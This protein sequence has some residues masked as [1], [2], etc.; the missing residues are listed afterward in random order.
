LVALSRRLR[1]DWHFA[2]YLLPRDF[3]QLPRSPEILQPSAST[4]PRRR[5]PPGTIQAAFARY[6]RMQ[7]EVSSRS[8]RALLLL[9]FVLAV[10]SYW[11]L[12]ISEFAADYFSQKGDRVSLQRAI[13]LQPG[14]A[15]F[16]YRLGRYFWLVEQ[17]SESAEQSYQ[18]ALALNPYKA[19]YWLDLAAVYQFLGNATGQQDALEHAV[20][21]APTTPEVAWE[22]ANLFLVQGEKERALHEFRIVLEN[23]PHLQPAALQLCLRVQPD[24][25]ALLRDVV[26]PISSVYL[27]FLDLL[28]SKKDTIAAAKVWAQLAH[29]QQ[30]FEARYVFEYIRYLVG[31]REVDQAGRVWEQ[32]ARL[33][34]LSAYQ[35]S[36]NNLVING[37][38][39]LPVLNG[40]FD[41]LYE[42]SKDVSLALDPS[43]FHAGRRS[44]MLSFD[45]RGIEDAGIRH[46][47]PVQAN[48]DYDFSAYFKSE[49]IQG[50]GGPRFAIQDLYTESAYFVSEPLKDATSWRQITGKFTT[51]PATRLLVLT[52]KRVPPGSPIRGKLWID[53]IHLAPAKP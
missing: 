8:Q 11:S 41:W 22:A 19:R 18:A 53:A 9:I 12:T 27:E 42:Q 26:P 38:F 6:L 15:T 10:L 1:K 4:M 25:D 14:N 31:Q 49:D 32:A 16:H 2:G 29:L 47:I 3:Y 33:C 52:I 50:A 48:A 37:D 20:I 5:G 45:S 44:L 30:P 51:G 46:L 28:I 39:S 13:R 35:P 21:A 17:S 7:I 23:D 43:Q 36:A 34:G 24:V 40:G